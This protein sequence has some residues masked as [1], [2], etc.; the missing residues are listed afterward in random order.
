MSKVLDFNTIKRPTLRLVMQDE[1]K[2][3][4]N[5]ALPAEGL[6]EELQN[7]LPEL[8]PI[9]SRGDADSIR[10]C[11]GLAAKL[12]NCNRSFVT[13]TADDLRNKYDMDLEALVVFFNA[14]VGFISEIAN[15]KNSASRTTR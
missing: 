7:M 15:E 1:A 3:C 2:T 9:L 13:V 12:I 8:T 5:V 11:Y 14:Y 6:I 4:I 10:E